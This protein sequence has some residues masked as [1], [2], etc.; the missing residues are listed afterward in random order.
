MKGNKETKKSL[1][2]QNVMETIN[3]VV[4]VA[5]RIPS[6]VSTEQLALGITVAVLA[7]GASAAWKLSQYMQKPS[8]FS[9]EDI[10]RHRTLIHV[11][12]KMGVNKPDFWSLTEDNRPI[13]N[14][15]YLVLKDQ[16]D[17]AV[18][19]LKQF[20]STNTF[21]RIAILSLLSRY[22]ESLSKRLVPGE[23]S[24][25][26]EAMFL[27][28][29]TSWLLT[30]FLALPD[31]GENSTETMGKRLT[32]C[33]DVRL[34]LS[35]NN[36][37]DSTR[38]NFKDLLDKLCHELAN[39]HTNLT[40]QSKMV[41]YNSLVTD[42]S[43]QLLAYESTLFNMLYLL[44]DGAHQDRLHIYKFK[45]PAE[46]DSKEINMRKT[47]LGDWLF[48]TLST[49]GIDEATFDANNDLSIKDIHGHL[50][51]QHPHDSD[52]NLSSDVRDVK[53]TQWGHWAFVTEKMPKSTG[54]ATSLKTKQQSVDSTSY[55]QIM[56]LLS[57][58]SNQ[59]I[60]PNKRSH[61]I[62]MYLAS[63]RDIHRATLLICHLR[64]KID[65]SKFVTGVFG[66]AWIYGDPAGKAALDELLWSVRHDIQL[67]E[68]IVN[69]FWDAYF[70]HYSEYAR[71]KR[72][73]SIEHPCH[74][75]LNTINM[76]GTYRKNLVESI[77]D[78]VTN[79]KI[80]SN[81]LPLTVAKANQSLRT[82]YQDILLHM[83][84]YNRTNGDNYRTIKNALDELQQEKPLSLL[85]DSNENLKD[86][87]SIQPEHQALIEAFQQTDLSLEPDSSMLITTSN[88]N[89]AV[90]NS[91]SPIHVLEYEK[92][93][94][95][96]YFK[97]DEL[98]DLSRPIGQDNP[99]RAL[100]N[101]RL[102]PQTTNFRSGMMQDIYFNY[103]VSNHYEVT[104]YW[105]AYFTFASKIPV[106]KRKQF[107][108]AYVRINAVFNLLYDSSQVEHQAMEI[109]MVLVTTLLRSIIEHDLWD[110]QYFGCFP[111]R[112]T[113][114][115]TLK[116][117]SDGSG[118][119][120]VTLDKK[121]FDFG[122]ELRCEEIQH[123]KAV[124]Q[125]QHRQINA[126]TAE[127]DD[128]YQK[129]KEKDVVIKQQDIELK[130]MKSELADKT[131]QLLEN[132]KKN[133]R[134]TAEEV[135]SSSAFSFH[136]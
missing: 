122:D 21:S 5:E 67:C 131:Q 85:A 112:T 121:W 66:Q 33:E 104:H 44:I 68:A 97:I 61:K 25:G 15:D 22:L 63:I 64:K 50:Q 129:L 45:Q 46:S 101:Y 59:T 56:P 120:Q 24:D 105:L 83:E 98:L 107:Q 88:N 90:V 79:I 32:Y 124:V 38:A 106:S 111:F 75:W 41:S 109:E 28:E 84:F 119:I 92:S 9:K 95:K 11:Y 17:R 94:F 72:V 55:E 65:R 42:L 47:I 2:N 57:A 36:M 8:C 77:S 1:S 18:D 76:S 29:M 19:T 73:D 30:K 20:P 103:L 89:N 110:H 91:I 51:G 117:K 35:Q 82:L 118:L 87:S 49:A 136:S 60:D 132:K 126:V 6:S 12:E 135:R 37:F 113:P 96:Y 100:M 123:L 114:L 78:L 34:S 39:Y 81:A 116:E 4:D 69:T 13:F 80:N 70:S 40:N 54:Q 14:L 3:T 52:C 130:Q 93:A 10:V 16:I 43:N 62:A 127:R 133:N 71:I 74:K 31:V 134:S 27:S 53:S 115:L 125:N 102:V 86:D 108:E 99:L 23:R 58:V 128:L 26:V 48:K 7:T